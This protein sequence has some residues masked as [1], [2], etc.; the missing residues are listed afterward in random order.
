M[1]TAA[2]R[3]SHVLTENGRRLLGW[4][5]HE[6]NAAS[7]ALTDHGVTMRGLYIF[8][9]TRFRAEHRY[10]VTFAFDGGDHDGVGASKTGSATL[11]F[12]GGLELRWQPEAGPP[13]P[14]PVDPRPRRVGRQLR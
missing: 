2:H 12:E 6:L 4:H 9:P 8:Y 11:N 5:W 13:A 1:L 14:K 3:D 7:V 10:E